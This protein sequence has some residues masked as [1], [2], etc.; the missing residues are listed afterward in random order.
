VATW[1]QPEIRAN[2]P[3]SFYEDVRP[4]WRAN[5][6]TFGITVVLVS[7]LGL[8]SL[9]LGGVQGTTRVV[10]SVVV[11]TLPGLAWLALLYQTPRRQ[12]QRP[13]PLV[14]TLFVLGALIAAAVTRPILTD[15]FRVNEWLAA[16]NAVRRFTT[17]VLISGFWH[18]FLLYS[19][20]RF[21]VWRTPV[22]A[23]RADGILYGMAAGWG[24]ATA[25]NLL[26]VLDNNGLA[27]LNG[28]L[29]LVADAC[30]FVTTSV[31]LGYF[32][33][34]N[35]FEVMP[36]YF[37]PVGL[38]LSA[39]VNGLLLFTTKEVNAIRIGLDQDGYSPW[40]GVVIALLVLALVLFAVFGIVRRENT[41][42]RTRLERGQ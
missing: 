26:F 23:H 5:T 41:L 40:P 8:A 16:T 3:A 33:G 25:T 21:T 18:T 35:R 6:I 7:T 28:N 2:A 15:L 42:T 10:I 24:Y 20:V 11:A 32:L 19:M 39:G 29:R 38:A 22:F 14:L 1:R 17:T 37:L 27:L 12:D 34:R 4:L 9:A 30:A 36:F 31:V 13:S